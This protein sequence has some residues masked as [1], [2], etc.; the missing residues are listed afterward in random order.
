[1]AEKA[2]DPI[3]DRTIP[4][5]K[6]RLQPNKLESNHLTADLEKYKNFLCRAKIKE[7]LQSEREALLT[8]LASKI[9]DKER[10]IDSRMASYSE[11]GRFL[12]E[13]AAKVVWI[14][15]QTNK[16]ENMKSLCSA[17]LDDLSAYPML[18]TRMTSFMEKLKQA[19]QENYD[20]W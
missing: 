6:S 3:I 1:V 11:Q 16:L 18:N 2:L 12:T 4:I 8:Q 9:V 14:R 5:L 17:L 13:I 15:Q 20:Q 10:E 7:K 19:E